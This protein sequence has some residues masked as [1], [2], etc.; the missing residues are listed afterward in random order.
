ML[1]RPHGVGCSM[2]PR[3]TTSWSI[4]TICW[5]ENTTRRSIKIV[6]CSTKLVTVEPMHECDGL[7]RDCRHCKTEYMRKYR[8]DGRYRDKE[9]QH[10]L[11]SK[12]WPMCTARSILF[13]EV[14]AGRI[15]NPKTL[16]CVDCG[17]RAQCYDHRDYAKPLEV[18]PVCRSCNK[19]RGPGLNKRIL[20]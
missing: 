19:F 14:R 7:K 8:K 3:S 20:A 11:L 10:Y 17:K 15:A 16:K 13:I 2:P 18:N 9:R 4:D 6:P 5:L 12:D 1:A